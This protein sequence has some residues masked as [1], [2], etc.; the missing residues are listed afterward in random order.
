M[1]ADHAAGKPADE[2]V[3][4]RFERI[5]QTLRTR[6]CMLDY[7]P[8]SR[9]REEDLAGEFGVSRTPLRRVLVKLEAEG[10]LRSVHGVGTIVTDID[11]DELAQ[12]YELRIELAELVGKLSPVIVDAALIA[13]FR[14]I[15]A[16][17][18]RMVAEGDPREFSRINMEFFHLFTTLTT[19][20]PL[21]E[22]SERLYYQ[23]ARIWLKTASRL[24][25]FDELLQNEFVTFQREVA[26]ITEAVEH[27]DL[28]AAGYVRRA[29]I[30]MSFS[31]IRQASGAEAG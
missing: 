19:N 21:R 22:I 18:D 28:T 23:T 9:L 2:G 12:V 10:L 26:D 8:G 30:A 16:R 20:E 17:C 6:I 29:H 5:Y 14:D 13:R 11:V 31:R 27:G 3:R 4:G 1:M 7:A 25:G 24:E 15:R